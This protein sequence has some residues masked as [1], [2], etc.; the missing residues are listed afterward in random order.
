MCRH[1]GLRSEL[2]LVC[3]WQDIFDGTIF[4]YYYFCYSEDRAIM[5]RRGRRNWGE[6]SV[7]FCPLAVVM[8]SQ[9]RISDV[10]I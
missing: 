1:G 4:L 2:L 9:V 3:S 6:G 7:S 8:C 5:E 10:T